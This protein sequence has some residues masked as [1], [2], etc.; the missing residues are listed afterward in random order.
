V[1]Q[2]QKTDRRMNGYHEFKYRIVF[3]VT[4]FVGADKSIE[5]I[6]EAWDNANRAF[7]MCTKYMTDKYGYGPE[8]K[9]VKYMMA[10]GGVPLWATRHAY[11]VLHTSQPDTIYLRDDEARSKIEEIF[12]F[13]QLKYNS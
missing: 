8:L 7:L 5:S 9:L 1:L 2:I 4:S 11:T 10:D 13:L 6:K 12:I 3:G